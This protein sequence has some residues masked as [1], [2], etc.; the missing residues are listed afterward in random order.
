VRIVCLI[1]VLGGFVAIHLLIG[2]TRLL[3]A[4]PGYAAISAAAI[5]SVF[6]I[7]RHSAPPQ[8]WAVVS[9]ILFFLYVALRAAMSP[10]A[11]LAWPDLFASLSCLAIYL[12]FACQLTNP[13]LRLG[14]VAMLAGLALAAVLIGAQQF[15]DGGDWMPFGFNRPIGYRG[16][17]SGFYICPNHLAGFLEVTGLFSVAVAF[18]SRLS[19]IWRLVA[20]YVSIVCLAGILLSGSRGGFLSMVAGLVVLGVLT[21]I[22]LRVVVRISVLR[23]VVVALA[24]VA[25]GA[26]GAWL[27]VRQSS[28]LENRARKLLGEHDI[29]PRLWAAAV[30]QARTSPVVGAGAGTYLYFGRKF[31]QPG[32][33]RDP[34]HVHNDYLELLAEYGALGLGCGLL[35]LGIHLRAGVT[36]FRVLCRR[37]ENHPRGLSNAAAL[38]IGALASVAAYVVHS[39]LDFNLHIPENAILLAGVAGIL[40]NPSVETDER[41]TRATAAGSRLFLPRALLVAVGLVLAGVTLPKLPGEWYAEH[42]RFALDDREFLEASRLARL[43]IERQTTNPYL[44]FYLGEANWEQA[45]K[46]PNAAVARSYAEAAV[47]AYQDALKDF[48]QDSRTLLQVGWILARLG[49]FD[50]AGPYFD[51]A[52][53]WD[54]RNAMIRTYQGHFFRMKGENAGAMAAYRAALALG[55]DSEAEKSL[56]ELE[57]ASPP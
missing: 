46:L 56:R 9:A 41:Q 10:V 13:G 22:R 18:W 47:V 29:R 1:L 30:E 14:W 33:D 57:A 53:A 42:A 11:Y 31:R 24:V 15:R 35:F 5:L 37:G 36:G 44:P 23:P 28:F 52:V 6:S 55:P 3:Y 40:A 51:S 54:P 45:R 34:V 32:V 48:P 25:L 39:F 21:I 20:G 2:G 27:A 7:R 50:E 38:N 12:L 19:V 49:R 17:A 8:R 43:G 4:I 26:G 16:R